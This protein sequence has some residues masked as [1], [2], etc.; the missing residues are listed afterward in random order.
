MIIVFL[1]WPLFVHIGILID[2]SC[3]NLHVNIAWQFFRMTDYV[4]ILYPEKISESNYKFEIEVQ[5]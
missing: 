2:Y 3:Q 1:V 5:Q 4:E